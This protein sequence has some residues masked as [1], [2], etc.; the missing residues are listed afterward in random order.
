M[1]RLEFDVSF[2]THHGKKWVVHGVNRPYQPNHEPRRNEVKPGERGGRILLHGAELRGGTHSVQDDA[3][4][5]YCAL[6]NVM[7]MGHQYIADKLRHNH[8]VRL[9]GAIGTELE[10]AACLWM[11]MP[12]VGR[13]WLSTVTCYVK[14]TRNIST[15][16]ATSP[17]RIP[18]QACRAC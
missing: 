16:D 18:T 9:D 2:V 8:F 7:P 15:S 17:Q 1:S 6:A 11:L 12:G 13:R 4:M 5:K 3:H 10:H 14:F